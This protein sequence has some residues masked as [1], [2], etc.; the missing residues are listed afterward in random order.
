[1][2]QLYQDHDVLVL[3]SYNEAIGMVVPEAMSSGIP[4]ITSDTVGANVYVLPGKNG[5]IFETGNVKA[6]KAA[7]QEYVES[8]S[9]RYR[10]GAAAAEHVRDNFTASRIAE[11]FLALAHHH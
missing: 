7:L 4:T 5:L 1:M 2:P 11:R 8:P 6:L 3:P 9:L 10:H